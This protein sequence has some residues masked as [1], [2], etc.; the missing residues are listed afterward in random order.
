MSV[1]A[2]HALQMLP[3]HLLGNVDF[4]IETMMIIDYK[5]GMASLYM[6][7]TDANRFNYQRLASC[8]LLR[9]TVPSY[10]YLYFL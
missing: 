5:N 8:A 10:N 6:Q 2:L 4:L 7:A 1:R 9:H 3:G